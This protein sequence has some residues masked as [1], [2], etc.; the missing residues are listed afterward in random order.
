M[1]GDQL[2]EDY[3]PDMEDIFGIKAKMTPKRATVTEEQ[4]TDPLR[5]PKVELQ[6]L[7]VAEKQPITAKDIEKRMMEEYGQSMDPKKY[8]CKTM[9][10]LLQACSDTV[11]HKRRQDGVHVYCARVSEA[12]QDIMEMV[13]Q[14]TTGHQPKRTA[15]S[16]LNSG[17]SK[18]FGNHGSSFRQYK[19]LGQVLDESSTKST[20]TTPDQHK[21]RSKLGPAKTVAR[22]KNMAELLRECR[23][24]IGKSHPD[25]PNRIIVTLGALMEKFK[26]VYGLPA[27][28]KNM[29]E[30]DLYLQINVPEFSGILKFWRLRDDGDV[31]VEE[32]EPEK[33]L[34]I[35]EESTPSQQ[36]IPPSDPRAD[37]EE[38]NEPVAAHPTYEN[39]DSPPHSDQSFDGFSSISSQ[40]SMVQLISEALHDPLFESGPGFGGT[41]QSRPTSRNSTTVSDAGQR[42]G[43]VSLRA[44]STNETFLLNNRQANGSE[45]AARSTLSVQSMRPV[46]VPFG[47]R[48]SIVPQNSMKL[49]VEYVSSRGS[50]KFDSLPFEDQNLVN[51]N[52]DIFKV[53]STKPGE[54]FVALDDPTV[55]ASTVKDGNS[56][57]CPV[58][59][60]LR[61]MSEFT[62][63]VK[64]GRRY[65]KPVMFVPPRGFLLMLSSPEEEDLNTENNMEKIEGLLCGALSESAKGIERLNVRPGMAAV[66]VYRQGA[67]VRYYRVLVTG[68]AQED[69]D[70]M[71][72]LADHS[73]QH[74]VD[75]QISNL[76][77]LPEKASF[78][79]YAP[80]VIF[81]TL[82]ATAGFT[83]DEQEIVFKNFDD[84]ERKT[85]VVGFIPKD[86]S[87]NLSIDMI[88]EYEENGELYWFS[89]IAKNRGAIVSSDFNSSHL[90]KSPRE[91]IN[92]YGSGC[93]MVF[94]TFKPDNVGEA[95]LSPDQF[96]QSN[97]LNSEANVGQTIA[98]FVPSMDRAFN[99]RNLDAY[100]LFSKLIEKKDGEAVGNMIHFARSVHASL[101]GNSEWAHLI[102]FMEELCERYDFRL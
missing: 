15:K 33:Q 31:F 54:V 5:K 12:N 68:K 8:G 81:A 58:E 99:P 59:A 101:Q 46:S 64:R 100:A 52:S 24:E 78:R 96:R 90:S 85:F 89:Q 82:Y 97:G 10:E 95:T 57:R 40:G 36:E 51:F 102:A 30:S 18:A 16:F 1:P 49:L 72:L 63:S 77:E 2:F 45:D 60:D 74:I 39:A 67:V 4:K 44:P 53:I 20:K 11:V 61:W 21:A 9:D 28:G 56:L 14:Q 3:D 25:H 92:R 98:Q 66:Y 86:N 23:T 6:G 42:L 80:N 83:L 76:F 69:G 29:S 35:A 19:S 70:L 93:Y 37:K 55:D 43:N 7:L 47:P 88:L 17:R 62:D 71:V 84:E 22:L 26:Q 73:D 27:W 38:V 79:R 41:Q 94:S 13:Q 34:F 91:T 65:F 32:D 75:V 87:K 48:R 50:V